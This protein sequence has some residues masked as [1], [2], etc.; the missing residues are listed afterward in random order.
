MPVLDKNDLSKYAQPVFIPVELDRGCYWSK[1]AFC[2]DKTGIHKTYKNVDIDHVVA[3]MMH[4]HR[5]YGAKTFQLCTLAASPK[6]LRK[7]VDVLERKGR[8]FRL[9]TW[10]RLDDDLTIDLIKRAYDVGFVNINVAPESFCQETLDLMRKGFNIEHI[11]GVLDELKQLRGRVTVA[12]IAGFP[13]DAL[14]NLER[15]MR[16]CHERGYT[17]IVLPFQIEHSSDIYNNPSSYGV[18]LV[19]K[20]AKR[21][22]AVTVRYRVKRGVPH[23]V[24]PDVRAPFIEKYKRWFVGGESSVIG[25]DVFDFGFTKSW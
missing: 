5:K 23:Y 18:A 22:I 2:V 11:I 21:D 15:S 6:R 4:L 10:A 13:G 3:T 12:L 14:K 7:L 1:C 25:Y 20:S 8:K 17:V 9:S 24:W 16:V 19:G